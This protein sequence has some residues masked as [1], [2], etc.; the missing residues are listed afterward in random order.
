[1]SSPISP[2]SSTV[3][4]QCKFTIIFVLNQLKP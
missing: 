3:D 4:I 1:M 2:M